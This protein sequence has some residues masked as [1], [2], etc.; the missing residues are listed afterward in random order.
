MSSHIEKVTIP[1]CSTFFCNV[2][3]TNQSPIYDS[4][5]LNSMFKKLC[6]DFHDL[7]MELFHLKLFN[8]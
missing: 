4:Q 1:W 2:I 6:H 7:K 3:Q 5:F 8:N